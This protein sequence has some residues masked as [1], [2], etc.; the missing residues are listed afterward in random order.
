MTRNNIDAINKLIKKKKIV[1]KHSDLN[2][3]KSTLKSLC[4]YKF[5]R[6]DISSYQLEN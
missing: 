5:Y 6:L 1:F 2:A 4:K 3:Y